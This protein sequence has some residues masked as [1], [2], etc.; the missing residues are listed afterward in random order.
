[1]NRLTTILAGTAG[2][3]ILAGYGRCVEPVGWRTDATGKYPDAQGPREWGPEKN[4]VWRT[5]MPAMSNAIPVIVGER[6]FTCAD[7]C[8]LICI[9]KADGKIIWQRAISYDDLALSTELR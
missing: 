9:N 6:L 5:A 3:L 2:L 4:V 7:P 8:V 1:M